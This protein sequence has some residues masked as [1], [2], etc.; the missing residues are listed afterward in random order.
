MIKKRIQKKKNNWMKGI[1]LNSIGWAEKWI[2]R[3]F[4]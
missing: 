2:D 1:I 3:K 4:K